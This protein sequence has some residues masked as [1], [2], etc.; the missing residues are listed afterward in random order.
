MSTWTGAVNTD[1]N[2][3]GNW[4]SGGIGAGIPNAGVDAIFDGTATR[5][6]VLGGPRACRALTF[7]GFAYQVDLATF[8]LQANNNITFQANQSSRII[9][10]TGRLACNASGTITSN[11]G[12]WPLDFTINNVGGITMTLVD[13]MRVGG[14]WL[15]SGGGTVT[16]A[17]AFT[18]FVGTNITATNGL[19]APVTNI[20]M[21]GSGTYSGFNAYN[22]EINTTG[23]IT[24][25]GGVSFT[26]KFIITNV[27]SIT[28][29]AANVTIANATTV[30]LGGRTIGNL[31]HAISVPGSPIITYST[32]VV[33]SNFTIGN[34]GTVIYNG[35]GRVLVFGNY[36]LG[37]SAASTSTLVVELKG[38][39]TISPGFMAL[40]C[41]VNSI[42]T[43]TLGTPL[44]LNSSLSFTCTTST[45]NTGTGTVIINN[46]VTIVPS[47]VN[48]YNITIPTNATITIN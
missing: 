41:I 35:P 20:V 3:A 26:R 28:M 7:T 5:D 12:T 43:Y 10:T 11:S 25:T 42:G 38:T 48:W 23:S 19:F 6:C 17:G 34:S 39:G 37:G 14:S 9:G 15:G 8:T 29:T 30:N 21:N 2:N 46:G 1:W 32:D 45:L 31:T 18:L 22:L 40:S 27:G 47:T 33:C 36:N 24:I 4:T 13:D 16:L 44:T